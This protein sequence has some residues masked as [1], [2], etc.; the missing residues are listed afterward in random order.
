MQHRRR[1]VGAIRPLPDA[2]HYFE[3]RGE[4]TI[5][6]TSAEHYGAV[7]NLGFDYVPYLDALARHGLNYTRIYPGAYFETP[8]YFVSDNVLGPA[9]DQLILPWARS[10]VPGYS[11]GGNKFDLETWDEAYFARLDDF[12]A[13]SSARGIVVETCFYNCMYPDMW[14]HMPLN[15]VNNIQ[16]E[17]TATHLE[18]Q[19]LA[20]LRLVRHQ[21]RYVREITR[22]LNAYDNV[23]WEIID[24]PTL[25]GTAD[26]DTAPWMSR[27]IDAVIDEESKLPNRHMIAQQIVGVFGGPVDFSDDPR[28]DIATGQYVDRNWGM[29]IGGMQ[30]LDACWMHNK[31]IE[32]NETAYFPNWY[33]EGDRVAAVRAEAWEFVV[34]GGAGYNHLNAQFTTDNP[35][36]AGTITDDVMD[37]LSKLMN[38]MS[39]V[40]YTRM[41][42]WFPISEAPDGGFLRSLA[43][44]GEQY[45]LY[46]HHSKLIRRQR[47]F[48]TFGE[49]EHDLTLAV[50]PGTYSVEWIDP[51]TLGSI[52]RTTVRHEGA[53]LKIKT[54]KHAMDIAL[55]ML[56]A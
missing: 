7:L 3:F 53:V 17:G 42:P 12:V 23:I 8:G 19:T 38:F 1:H 47:Y 39:T 54:P 48:P 18:F 28:I 49:Y 27:M 25:H 29:Q 36:A 30:V 41:E 34:G 44:R 20:D 43:E 32:L 50:P 11:Q 33:E 51:K 35:S 45:I 46:M 9:N 6:I 5:L 14:P 37:M 2:P 24:E 4:P 21:E 55:R 15:A 16:G 52:E 22:R 10:S 31:P 40:D 26:A 13:Q 56:R